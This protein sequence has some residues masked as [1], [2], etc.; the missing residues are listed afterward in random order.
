MN[1][2]V[3]SLKSL[4]WSSAFPSQPIPENAEQTIIGDATYAYL[5]YRIMP[6]EVFSHFWSPIMRQKSNIYEQFE[7]SAAEWKQDTMM[8]SSLSIIYSHPAYQRIIGLG[9]DVLPLILRSLKEEPYF[10]F[11]AL[12]AITGENPIPLESFGK[13]DEMQKAWLLWAEENKINVA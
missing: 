6:Q 2:E 7:C 9:K 3:M 4:D 5:H 13:M 10:W 12:T 1:I 8:D 11:G